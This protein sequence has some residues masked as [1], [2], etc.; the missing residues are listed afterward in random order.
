MTKLASYLDKQPGTSRL[1]ANQLFRAGTSISANLEE[2]C[3]AESYR[4]FISKQSIALKEA[5]ETRYWLRLLIKSEMM[6]ETQV[7]NLLDECEQ[8]IKIIGKSIV[9]SKGKP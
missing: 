1:W 5:K 2:S 7:E 3:S 6:T 4:D 9:T 8:L